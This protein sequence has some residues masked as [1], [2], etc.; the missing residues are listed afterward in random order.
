MPKAP[1]AKASRRYRLRVL[2]LVAGLLASAATLWSQPNEVRYA[3]GEIVASGGNRIGNASG[4]LFLQ[5]FNPECQLSARHP[6]ARPVSGFLGGDVRLLLKV[7]ACPAAEPPPT[8]QCRVAVGGAEQ[9][10]SFTGWETDL[11]LPLPTRTGIFPLSL[12]CTFQGQ[13]AESFETLLY[14]T[15]PAAQ[16]STIMGNEV[17]VDWYQRACSWG[18]DLD[19]R[20]T[21]SEVLKALLAGLYRYGQ[22]HWRYGYGLPAKACEFCFGGEKADTCSCRCDWWRLVDEQDPCK[23]GDCFK[24]T[25]VLQNIAA[26]MG[27][28]ITQKTESGPSLGFSTRPRLRSLDPAFKGNLACGSRH[29]PCSVSFSDTQP[30]QVQRAQV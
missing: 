26:L 3:L 22:E 5:T 23:S 11:S 15:W 2:W 21:E 20:A 9:S 17:P 12:A 6:R 29:S 25:A 8:A 30:H 1:L 7:I 4:V 14:M 19:T 13:K 24:F 18:A 28:V 16:P 27:L 10:V